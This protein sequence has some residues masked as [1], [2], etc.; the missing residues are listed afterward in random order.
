[1][2]VDAILAHTS[3]GSILA[4]H[5]LGL[6]LHSCNRNPRQE[7]QK[8]KFVCCGLKWIWASMGYMRLGLKITGVSDRAY[9]QHVQATQLDPHTPNPKMRTNNNESD[10]KVI[11]CTQT[12]YQRKNYSWFHI[13]DSNHRLIQ[14]ILILGNCIWGSEEV[15]RWLKLFVAF[16]EDPGLISSLQATVY[17]HL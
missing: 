15:T 5:R 13:I 6:V 10:L 16:P 12:S 4:L 3:P 17:N 2:L 7:S 1:M 8:N 11:S 9:A 14:N